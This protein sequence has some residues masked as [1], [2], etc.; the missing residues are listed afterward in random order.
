MVA[1]SEYTAPKEEDTSVMKHPPKTD[2]SLNPKHDP[3]RKVDL[4]K[5]DERDL[6]SLQKSGE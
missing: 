4:S 3:D 6:K 1:S 5:M 2:E